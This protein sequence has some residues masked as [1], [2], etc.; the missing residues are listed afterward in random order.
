MAGPSRDDKLE[1][2][3]SAMVSRESCVGD[4][5][6]ICLAAYGEAH[7]S[8]SVNRTKFGRDCI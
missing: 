7:D 5:V 1:R 2:N 4:M 6:G 3:D 8:K